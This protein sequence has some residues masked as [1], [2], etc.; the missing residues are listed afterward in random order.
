MQCDEC[1]RLHAELQKTQLQIDELRNAAIED[2]KVKDILA[3]RLNDANRLNS[4]AEERGYQRAYKEQEQR[5]QAMKDRC[6]DKCSHSGDVVCDYEDGTSHCLECIAEK[7]WASEKRK[8]LPP[9]DNPAE[10]RTCQHWAADLNTD[11]CPTCGKKF[12]AGQ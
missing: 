2:G 12:G 1:I 7:V 10:Q 5:R 9:L 6:V 3:N 8:P 11:V 4:E